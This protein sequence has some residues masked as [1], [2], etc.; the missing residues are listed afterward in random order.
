MNK[1]KGLLTSSLVFSIL[2]FLFIIFRKNNYGKYRKQTF[3]LIWIILIL[4]L[5]VP[6][7]GLVSKIP[8]QF[9]M[10]N[11]IAKDIP[12]VFAAVSDPVGTGL[13]EDI[14]NPI[15]MTG[16]SDQIQIN[17]ILNFAKET[18]ILNG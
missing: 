13:I 12:V 9:N 10:I 4:R 7:G 8:S 15:N 1:V 17:E 3:R 5:L 18:S 16:T 6:S 11:R 14:D 2:Y